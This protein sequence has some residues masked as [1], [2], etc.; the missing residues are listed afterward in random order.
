MEYDVIEIPYEGDSL[1]ML[2]VSPF[3]KDVPL[4]AIFKSLEGQRIKQWRN[5]MRMVRRQLSLPR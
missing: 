2:I 1:S 4:S 3:E 5:G